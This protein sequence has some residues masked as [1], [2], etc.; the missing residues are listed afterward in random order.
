[1][2]GCTMRIKYY[3][4]TVTA[5]DEQHK[6]YKIKYDDGDGEDLNP[7]E[8]WSVLIWPKDAEE[9]DSDLTPEFIDLTSEDDEPDR[10][11]EDNTPSDTA[12]VATRCPPRFRKRS[13]V[14]S[15]APIADDREE[16][17]GIP[18]KGLAHIYEQ[19]DGLLRVL[20]P[21][22]KMRAEAAR[23]DG[24]GYLRLGIQETV[25]DAVKLYNGAALAQG[26][27]EQ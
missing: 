5:Y 13:C 10:T 21:R 8:L 16:P 19:L 17:N 18:V 15:R 2:N 27:T 1:M 11:P 14:N 6:W 22:D 20:F 12:D 25:G 24:V 3:R 4:G 26:A 7:K 9:D 23:R